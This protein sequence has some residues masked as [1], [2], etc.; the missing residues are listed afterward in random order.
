[1]GDVEPNVLCIQYMVM[2]TKSGCEEVVRALRYIRSSIKVDDR[3][4]LTSFRLAP[5]DVES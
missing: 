5:F 1:M 3:S 4:P 2:L